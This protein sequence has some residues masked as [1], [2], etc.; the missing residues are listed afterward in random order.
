MDRGLEIVSRAYLLCGLVLL[1]VACQRVE[2]KPI[3]VEELRDV[4]KLELLEYR[5]EEIFVIS[6]SGQTFATIRTL[7]EAGDYFVDLLR[8]GSRVGVYAFDNYSVA[9][10]DLYD[11]KGEDIEVDQKAGRVR[12]TLPQVVIEPIGRSGTLRVLH[13]RVTGTKPMI[14]NK[15]R[16]DMQNKASILA[17]QR[18][19]EGTAK[20]QELLRK[21]EAKAEA[22]F[23]GM[24]QARGY[25]EVVIEISRQ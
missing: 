23:R 11:L 21:A 1:L 22:Y 6:G 18:V 7:E 17:K 8:V 19:A 25:E 15:E 13:E 2:G 12:L 20:H 3:E 9:Y 4:G 10:M 16:R 24:L 5:T 14:T